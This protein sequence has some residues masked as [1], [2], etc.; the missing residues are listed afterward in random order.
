MLPMIKFS[1]TSHKNEKSDEG[2]FEHAL[3]NS[4]NN[5]FKD[6]QHHLDNESVEAP[7]K[8]IDF[9]LN[10][11]KAYSTK[12]LQNGLPVDMIIN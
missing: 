9:I 6:V 11:A 1:T 10:F 7:K 8:C 4:L 3:T 12:N 5:E 2:S